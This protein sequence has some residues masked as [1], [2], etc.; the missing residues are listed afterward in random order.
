MYTIETGY[1]PAY[2]HKNRYV[3]IM[4]NPVVPYGA[5]DLVKYFSRENISRDAMST[6][7]FQ[8]IATNA[9]FL[10]VWPSGTYFSY[11]PREN[12]QCWDFWFMKRYLKGISLNSIL[13]PMFHR[14]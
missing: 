8:A 1:A 5:I 2:E 9:D 13:P 10:S 12:Y 11:V 3:M 14:P 6:L 7:R 4:I